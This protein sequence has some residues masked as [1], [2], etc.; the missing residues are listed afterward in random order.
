MTIFETASVC[1]LC[2]ARVPAAYVQMEDGVH[3]ERTCPV[4]GTHGTLV[5]RGDGFLDWCS[6]WRPRPEK[7]L[8]CPTACGLC[9]DHQNETCCAI[10]DVTQRCNL[11]CG[12]CFANGGDGDEPPLQEVLESLDDIYAQG[13]RYLHLSGGEPTTRKDL[14]EI[15]AHASELGFEYIQLNSNGLTLAWNPDYA[16]ALRD[17]GLSCVFL[18]F[19]GTTNAIYESIRG[20][21]LMLAKLQALENCAV[22]EL[23][24][25]LV[26]TLVPGVN[27]DNIGEMVRFALSQAPNVRGIHFQPVAYTGRYGKACDKPS[28]FQ[29]YTIPELL[30]ALETQTDGLVRR[31][32]F[33]PSSC[34]SPLCGFH[35]EFQRVDSA[36]EAHTTRSC[37]C[38]SPDVRRNQRYVR[39]RWTRAL[40]D[41]DEPGS[42]DALL[43]EQNDAS[44]CMSAMVFQ[45][46]ETLD[47]GR[48]QR[49]S[50]HVYD[51][52]SF[53]P[54]CVYNN[55]WHRGHARTKVNGRCKDGGSRT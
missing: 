20:S 23:G 37:C 24:V 26:P 40:V 30:D 13:R 45:D 43:K 29:H 48:C 16:M 10:L 19:D 7:S 55:V 51:S 21:S 53:I 50:V 28:A 5:W 15:V 35:G 2:G 32:D 39:S 36:L 46:E 9:E 11:Q 12:F 31:G 6:G 27:T 33:A 34:D 14:P 42:T 4:H 1:P 8:A 49:C 41:G 47:L 18:Q 25:V 22:A 52:G 3:L 44:F 38:C 54:F 17:A